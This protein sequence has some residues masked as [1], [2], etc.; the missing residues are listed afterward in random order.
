VND[1]LWSLA[2]GGA[3]RADVVMMVQGLLKPAA[4]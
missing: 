4:K 3:E 1:P 2:A